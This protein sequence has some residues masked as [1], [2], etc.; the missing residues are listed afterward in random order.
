MIINAMEATEKNGIVRIWSENKN[1]KINFCV[2]NS[3]FIPPEISKRIFQRNFST[4]FQAGRGIGT[5][6][7]KFFGE[8]ILGGKVSFSSSKEDGTIFVLSLPL[9]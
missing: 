9:S 1:G 5:Y 2:W 8:K 7:M 4:K 6:S 3:Q